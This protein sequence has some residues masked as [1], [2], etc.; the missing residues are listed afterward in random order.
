LAVWGFVTHIIEYAVGSHAENPPLPESLDA[1]GEF[2]AYVDSKRVEGRV[3][4]ATASE[5]ASLAFPNP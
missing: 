1:L 2:L 4:Y 5:I 3:V